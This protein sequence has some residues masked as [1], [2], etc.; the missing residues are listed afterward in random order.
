[1][2]KKNYNKSFFCIFLGLHYL[3]SKCED[4]LRLGK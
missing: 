4:K 3:C 1:M 2:G